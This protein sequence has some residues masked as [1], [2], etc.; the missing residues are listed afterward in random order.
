M[1]IIVPRYVLLQVPRRHQSAVGVRVHGPDALQQ[2]RAAAVLP[3]LPHPARRERRTL[4]HRRIADHG[5][6]GS[7]QGQEA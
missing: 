2:S 6:R 4:F 7:S 3:A 5:R 1:I